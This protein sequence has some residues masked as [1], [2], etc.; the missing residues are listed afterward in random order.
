[1]FRPAPRPARAS[2]QRLSR[3]RDTLQALEPRLLF[4]AAAVATGAE[5]MAD[6]V[7]QEQAEAAVA[8]PEDHRSL[9]DRPGPRAGS[10]NRLGRARAL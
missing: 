9:S 6:A 3:V 2:A 4:D 1:M 5:A 8:Q 7:A 10:P